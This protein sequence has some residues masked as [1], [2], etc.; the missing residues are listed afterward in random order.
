[1]KDTITTIALSATATAGSAAASATGNTIM[2]WVT[3]G[4]NIAVLVTN[5]AISIYRKW[6]DRDKD[7]QDNKSEREE[8]GGEE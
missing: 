3:L 8:K 2:Q 7:I 5:C 4:I 1:M 6:R